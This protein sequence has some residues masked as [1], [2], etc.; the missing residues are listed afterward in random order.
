MRPSSAGTPPASWKSS[1]RNLPVGR[2]SASS[3]VR[4]ET[5]SKSSSVSFVP[6]RP[7]RA[8]RWTMALVEPPMAIS[9]VTAFSKAARVAIRD[10]RTSCQ[11]IS[12][13]RRPQATARRE[14]ADWT[15]G[16]DAAPGKMKPSASTT[17]AIVAAVPIVMHTPGERAMPSSISRQ[18]SQLIFPAQR[19]A[20]NFHASLPLP[21]VSLRQRPLSIGPAGRKTQGRSIVSAPMSSAGTVLSQPPISTAPSMG[22]QRNVSSTSI[23]VRFR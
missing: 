13:A 14:C 10:G 23:A 16:M 12:T 6:A 4:R 18:A 22:W 15:A 21:S 11:T 1:M 8:I 20:Q 5:R 2:M 19:S 7:A 9:V 3:G 17:Q